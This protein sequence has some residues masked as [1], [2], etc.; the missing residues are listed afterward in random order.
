MDS[1]LPYNKFGLH[2]GCCCIVGTG[3]EFNPQNA[4]KKA[5]ILAHGYSPSAGKGKIP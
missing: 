5:G 4:C 3:P 1:E 2:L